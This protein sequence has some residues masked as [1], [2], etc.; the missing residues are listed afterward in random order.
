MQKILIVDDDKFVVMTLSRILK[1]AGYICKHVFNGRQ[2]ISQHAEFSP[3]LVLLD[4]KLPDMNGFEILDKLKAADKS[5]NVIMITSFNDIRKAVE[6]IKLGVFDYI[7]KPFDNDNILSVVRKALSVTSVSQETNIKEKMGDSEPLQK[8]LQN[9]GKVADKD[10]TVFLE[11]ET[12]TGKELFAGMIHQKSNRKDKPFVTVDCGAISETLFESELFGHTKGAFTGAIN[13]KKG[14]FL[15]A[16]GGTLFLDEINN[17]PMKMQ[18]KFLRALQ[19]NEIQRLGEEN[20][21]KT[22]VRII[23]ASNQNINETVRD[24]YF[25]E[26]L[27]YRI[28]EF[29]IN[30]PTLQERKADIPILAKYFLKEI[31]ENFELNIAGFSPDAMEKL[32]SYSWPGNIR[33]MKNVIKSAVILCESN[34]IQPQDLKPGSLSLNKEISEDEDLQL[35]KFVAKAEKEIIK[36]ALAKADNKSEAAELLG[37]SRSQFYKKLEKLGIEGRNS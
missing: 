32:L 13:D 17:L 36:K 2:A 27:F 37:I 34:E 35:D 10:I 23:V 22:D 7:T 15:T 24:G 4:F 12:G 11:G 9:I 1:K 6:A 19:E 3:D 18:P 25:R 30:L 16:E 14:K 28:H 26:D 21:R 8:V 29:K 20:P 31:T 5:V 33:E